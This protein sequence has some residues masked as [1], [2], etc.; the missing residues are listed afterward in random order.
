MIDATCKLPIGLALNHKRLRT[1]KTVAFKNDLNNIHLKF[2]N[3]SFFHVFSRVSVYVCVLE[4]IRESKMQ[5]TKSEK[6]LGLTMYTAYA[7]L[8]LSTPLSCANRY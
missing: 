8:I 5:I 3:L 4:S 7:L 6:K 1:E 2:Q